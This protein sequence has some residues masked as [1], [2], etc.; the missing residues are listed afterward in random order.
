MTRMTTGKM[1]LTAS[2][3]LRVLLATTAIAALPL[4]AHAA[5]AWPSR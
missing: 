2:I 5:D 1:S 3:A 4:G